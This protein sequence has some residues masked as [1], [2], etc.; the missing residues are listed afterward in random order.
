MKPSDQQKAIPFEDALR[1]FWDWRQASVSVEVCF[2]CGPGSSENIRVSIDGVVRFIDPE[3]IVTVSGDGREMDLDL[4]GCKITRAGEMAGKAKILNA[5]DPDAILQVKFPNGETCLVFPYRRVASPLPGQCRPE[6]GLEWMQSELSRSSEER[7]DSK[8][9]AGGIRTSI[10]GIRNRK[11]LKR[12]TGGTAPPIFPMA[13]F[14]LVFVLI[15]M[16]LTPSG[17]PKLLVELGVQHKLSDPNA[18]VWVIQRDGNYYCSGSVLNGRQPGKPMKQATALT[19]GYQPALGHY[20]QN[21]E[22]TSA[23]SSDGFRGSFFAYFQNVRRSGKA[24][25][26]KLSR[27][28]QAWLPQT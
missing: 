4:R 20:C 22:M 2:F 11:H 12:R 28:S 24:F 26:S 1:V 7:R 16:A 19:F 23:D 25:F 3:G 18:V 14:V 9:R 21:R 17:I 13:A 15:V 10:L 6:T 5:L 8:F 27:I